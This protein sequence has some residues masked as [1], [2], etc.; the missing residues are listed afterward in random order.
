MTFFPTILTILAH[1]PLWVWPLYAVLLLLGLQRSRDSIVPLWRFLIL[2]IIVA[3][4]A[5]LGFALSGQGT[6]PS[7]LAGLALG[8]PL[9]WWIEPEGSTR[10]LRT[11]ALWL[12]GEWMTLG[13]IGLVVVFRYTTSALA[14]M[15]PE[16][17]GNLNWRLGTIFVATALSATFLGRTA[18]RLCVIWRA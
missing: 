5:V 10:R 9:G 3:Q 16:L 7:L 17:H 8:G 14:G 11:G 6:F 1:T 2:P 13:Q 12:R 4:L 18:N 15:N